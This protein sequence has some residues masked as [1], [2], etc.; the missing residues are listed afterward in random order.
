MNEKW[1]DEWLED[2]NVYVSLNIKE[3]VQELISEAERRGY[4]RAMEEVKEASAS[5]VMTFAPSV[6]PEPVLIIPKSFFEKQLTPP[7]TSEVQ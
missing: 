7:P 2:H 5:S 3:D 6:K 1:W 4:E